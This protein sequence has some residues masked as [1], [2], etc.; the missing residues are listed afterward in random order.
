MS[1]VERDE[2]ADGDDDDND[3]DEMSDEIMERNMM[4]STMI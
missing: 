4:K 2:C 1:V 3:E